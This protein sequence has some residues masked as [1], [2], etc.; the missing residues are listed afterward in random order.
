MRFSEITEQTLT[1][2]SRP[3]SRNEAEYVLVRAGYAHLGRGQTGSV[4][5]KP[6]AAY[7]LKLFDARDTA[8]LDFIGLATANPNPHFPKFIGKPVRVNDGYHAIRTELLE[9]VSKDRLTEVV[10]IDKYIISMRNYG[11]CH[12]EDYLYVSSH[13]ELQEACDMLA[14]FL[15]YKNQYFCDIHEPNVMMRGSTLVMTDPVAMV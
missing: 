2:L 8:Y 6:G 5:Q 15:K 11:N 3:S 14:K 4:F 12:N 9:P 13:P 10:M 1:E 7:V